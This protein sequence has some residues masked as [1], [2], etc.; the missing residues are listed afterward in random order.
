MNIGF[1]LMV[2]EHS[3]VFVVGSVAG[4]TVVNIFPPR[5]LKLMRLMLIPV[6][7]K[8]IHWTIICVNL[9]WSTALKAFSYDPVM[10]K[11]NLTDFQHLWVHKYLSMLSVWY[12]RDEPN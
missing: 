5:N 8:S 11:N 4:N 9:D 10:D 6:N 7:L 3:D 2:R 12:R 1:H